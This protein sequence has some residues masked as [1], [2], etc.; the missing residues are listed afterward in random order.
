MSSH[1]IKW[2]YH[3]AMVPK[4][5]VL[6]HRI[7]IRIKRG[8]CSNLKQCMGLVSAIAT[9]DSLIY[10][11]KYWRCFRWENLCNKIMIN[12]HAQWNIRLNLS[13]LLQLHLHSRLNTWLQWIEQRQLQHEKR[14]I[15]VLG[16][17]VTYIRDFVVSRTKPCV[18]FGLPYTGYRSNW[19]S[20]LYG[21][22]KREVRN[23]RK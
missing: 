23:S 19:L 11:I 20:S 14:T 17:G 21:V 4:C 16:F 15:S 5:F 22:Y 6:K 18:Y 12:S 2:S 10:S 13:A 9:P 7:S 3:Y 8:T 1:E